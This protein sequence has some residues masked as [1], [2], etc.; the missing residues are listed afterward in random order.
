MGVYQ[1][2][3]QVAR[4]FLDKD[5]AILVKAGYLNRDLSFMERGEAA[6]LAAMLEKVKADVV[7]KAEEDIAENVKEN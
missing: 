4:R 3:T 2:L 1:T 7:A 5:I 6:I